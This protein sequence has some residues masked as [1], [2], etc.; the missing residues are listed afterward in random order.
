MNITGKI[1]LTVTAPYGAA[2]SAQDLARA[3]TDTASVR[4]GFM[5]A[6]AFFSEVRPEL[7][8]AFL[9]EMGLEP[10]KVREVARGFQRLAGYPLALAR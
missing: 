2:L 5:P 1:L 8:R 9:A 4:S 3:I 6:F 7:Q 10:L